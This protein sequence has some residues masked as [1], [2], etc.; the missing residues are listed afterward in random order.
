MSR[1]D[2]PSTRARAR[3][4]HTIL[5]SAHF[6]SL[7]RLAVLEPSGGQK[8]RVKRCGQLVCICI[9]PER[10]DRR[11][12]CVTG[13][14]ASHNEA[15]RSS[16]LHCQ[17]RGGAHLPEDGLCTDRRCPIWRGDAAHPL[18]ASGCDGAGQKQYPLWSSA[19]HSV[20]KWLDVPDEADLMEHVAI[21]SGMDGPL[22]TTY[23]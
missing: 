19:S 1:T 23:M 11:H 22:R 9:R 10:T 12:V 13:T 3:T 17:A 21:P 14:L 7:T 6:G 20:S 18:L 4:A 16:R 5:T 8:A 2:F 15:L